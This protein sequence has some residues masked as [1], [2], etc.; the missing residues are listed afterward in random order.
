MPSA[1]AAHSTC[2]EPARAGRP[3]DPRVDEAVRAAT[4]DL[5]VE[6]GYQA[7]TIQA[8][9]RRARVSAPSIY[10]R[11]SNKAAVVEEAVFPSVVLEPDVTGDLETQLESYCRRILDYLGDPAVRAA[12]PGLL[13]EYQTDPAM[14]HR[15]VERS[16]APMRVA[17]ATF[18][19]HSGHE[20]V[21]SPDALFEVLLG[22]L[23]VR[24]MNNGAQGAESF[25]SE[26]TRILTASLRPSR[27]QRIGGPH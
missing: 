24:A 22:T 5:L 9:A 1:L 3:R 12:I 27:R 26:V 6:D 18:L 11:W 8:I 25:A 20:P 21:G 17:F 16:V 19:E 10:R 15:L 7:T 23:C 2:H 4:L 14:W 13:T